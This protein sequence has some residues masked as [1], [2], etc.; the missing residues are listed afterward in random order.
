MI[1]LSVQMHQFLNATSGFFMVLAFFPKKDEY[2]EN[3]REYDAEEHAQNEHRNI[4]RCC[5]CHI[6]DGVRGRLEQA[7]VQRGYGVNRV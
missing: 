7:V 4:V 1:G 2:A 5:R 3:K 6:V